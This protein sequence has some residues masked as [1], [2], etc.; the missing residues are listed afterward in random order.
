[1]ALLVLAAGLVL[2]ALV[3]REFYSW[4]RLSHVPGPFWNS[5]TGW[6]L[7]R[8][9]LK[10]NIHESYMALDAEYGASSRLTFRSGPIGIV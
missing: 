3:A 7:V 2:A 10:G 6:A 8:M 9:A 5:V 1:M 4:Y